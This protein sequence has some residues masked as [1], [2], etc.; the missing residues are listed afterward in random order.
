MKLIKHNHPNP[1]KGRNGYNTYTTEDGRF[2]ITP[3]TQGSPGVRWK[4]TATDGS[5]PFRGYRGKHSSIGLA[6]N[7]DDVKYKIENALEAEEARKS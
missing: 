7:I 1:N 6:S 2:N 5:E 4:V 3:V